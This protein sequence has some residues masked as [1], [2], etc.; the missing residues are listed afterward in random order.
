MRAALALALKLALGLAAPV[1]AGDLPEG[2]VRL[3][4]VAPGIVQDIRYARAFNFT[5]APVPG[6]TAPACLLRREAAEALARVE[7]RLRA[8]GYRLTVFDCYRPEAAVAAFMDWVT[9]GAPGDERFFHPDVPR[10]RLGTEGYIAR[11]SSHSRGLT[12]DVGLDR[13]A[14]PALRPDAVVGRCDAPFADR[15]AESTLDMGTAFDCF[16][17]LSGD[18]AAVP[19]AARANRARLAG[20]MEAE[21]FAGYSA[22]WWHFRL[23]DVTPGPSQDFP[24]R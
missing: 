24:V 22:E 16:S 6:Y 20:A 13:A 19:E 5:G 17:L 8:E 15:P 4:E 10:G 11:R 12:V 21:G 9:T 7:A 2:W 3:A 18:A 1:A 14:A 23:Q